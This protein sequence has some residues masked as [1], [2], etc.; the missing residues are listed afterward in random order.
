MFWFAEKFFDKLFKIKKESQSNLYNGYYNGYQYKLYYSDSFTKRTWYINYK[1]KFRIICYSG[2]DSAVFDD[3][4][5]N[6]KEFLD[7]M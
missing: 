5:F 1:G 4:S 6:V 7:N 3:V 2:F